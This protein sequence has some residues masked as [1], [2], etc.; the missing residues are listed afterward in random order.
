MKTLHSARLIGLL[1]APLA[2]LHA[3]DHRPATVAKPNIVLILADDLGYSDLGCYGGEIKTP[4]LDKLAVGG[5]RFTQFYNGARCCPSRASILTGL[6]P[7][8]A[9]FPGMGGSLPTNCVT[10]PEVLRAAGYQTFMCGKWHLGNPDPIARGF[11]EYYGMLGGFGSYWNPKLY[12]RLPQGRPTRRYEDG[13]FY[14]TDAITDYALDFIAA[15]R[16]AADKPFFL[17]LAYNAPHFP[18]HAPKEEIAKYAK[19]YEQGWDKIRDAR[20]ARQQQLGLLDQPWPLSPRSIIPPN[21]VA[22]AHGWSNKQNPAWTSLDVER[23]ADLARR[24]AVFA[25][26]VDRMDQNIGRVVADLK[27]HGELDNTLIFFLS[28]NGACAEWDPFGF[29]VDTGPKNILHT[30]ADLDTI[31]APGSYNSYGSGWANAGNTPFRLYKHYSHEGG[32]ATPL[33]VHWPNGMKRVGE[34]DRRPGHISD[35]M[36]TCVEVARA[37]YPRDVLPR[38]GNSLLPALR[39]EPAEPRTIFFEHEGHRAVRNGKWKLVSLAGQP[40]E[41]YDMETDRVELNDRAAQEPERVRA[42][43]GQWDAWVNRMRAAGSWN[44]KPKPAKPK[45]GTIRD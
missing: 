39:G 42:L 16:K 23:R 12:T 8:E 34:F 29:D 19:L 36:A 6:Y 21:G 1:L 38:A 14:S 28:D 37:E 33:I 35:L 25:A 32:I 7:H 2:A 24:M 5:L 18:L 15:A 22:T 9:G 26:A 20:Y 27:Q 41:L 31:G 13:K 30:G 40:W 45:A 11:D 10:I 17:Y 44:A 4:N 3:A 43:A